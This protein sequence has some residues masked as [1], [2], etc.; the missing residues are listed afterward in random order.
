MAIFR[1]KAAPRMEARITVPGDKSISHRAVMFSALANGTCTVRNFLAGE[2]CRATI[3]AMRTLGIAI[4]ELDEVTVRIEGRRGEFSPPDRPIDCGN[5]GTT[6]RLLS[7]ILA[8]QPFSATLTGDAS[9]SRRPMKRVVDP[10]TM[11]GARLQGEGERHLPPLR[12]TGGPLQGIDYEMPMASAQVKSAVLLAGLFAK[13]RTSVVEPAACRDH[14]ERM[15]Q[16][17]LVPVRREGSRVMVHGRSHLEA[18][19]FT[20]PGDISSAA[21]WLVAAA[22]MPGSELVVENVGLNPTRTGLLGILLR[23]GARIRERVTNCAEAEPSGIIDLQGGNLQATVIGGA[24]VANVI[25][26][27]PI[28]AVAAALA[29]GKTIIRDAEELRVKETDRLAAIAKNLTAMGALVVEREGGLEIEGPARL[30]GATLESFGDHRIAMAFAVAGL[31]ARGE[32]IIQDVECVNTS[33]PGFADL[34]SKVQQGLRNLQP[35]R[36][37]VRV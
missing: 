1:V 2:D 22:A 14:T 6:L 34:L 37:L 33:Y 26:E 25:D 17:Y 19:D 13:G 10:L 18:R 11:M 21:F 12:I 28:L 29:Q 32:T 7:G 27:I 30:R 16:Y 3:A 24:E 20:V 15:L 4:E 8:G 36:K 35:M 9:L 5:S 31:F 23:M